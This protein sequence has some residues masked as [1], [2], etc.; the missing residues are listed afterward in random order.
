MTYT[1][2]DA[3]CVVCMVHDE[4]YARQGDSADTGK[5]DC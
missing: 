5:I 4:S 1:V 3:K 2:T